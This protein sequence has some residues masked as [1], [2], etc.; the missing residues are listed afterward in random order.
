MARYIDP[1]E[2]ADRAL[3]RGSRRELRAALGPSQAALNRI[4]RMITDGM[5]PKRIAAAIT[6]L[7]R[8]AGYC[9]EGN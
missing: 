2:K 5:P 8:S 4:S 1:I 9:M 7:K 3:Q 6:A